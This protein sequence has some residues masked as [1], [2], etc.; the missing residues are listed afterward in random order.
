M[1]DA[2]EAGLWANLVDQG[3]ALLLQI[4]QVDAAAI[5]DHQLEAA[6]DA[7]AGDRSGALNTSTRASRT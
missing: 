4:G 1:A 2:D 6:G 5:L 3:L 7:D